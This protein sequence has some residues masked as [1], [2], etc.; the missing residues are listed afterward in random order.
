MITAYL[1]KADKGSLAFPYA[2]HDG[3]KNIFE[4][5][6]KDAIILLCSIL[7]DKIK[8]ST[9]LKDKNFVV[10]STSSNQAISDQKTLLETLPIVRQSKKH[11]VILG[12]GRLFQ[13]AL[14]R[15][16]IDRV[17]IVIPKNKSGGLLPSEEIQGIFDIIESTDF[18]SVYQYD[19]NSSHKATV[20]IRW[21]KT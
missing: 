12:G 16:L 9:L 5:I 14:R 15:K 4:S 13:I 3:T 18:I 19:T 7:Y 8:D 1:V 20:D 11:I 10:V 17:V 6:T 2:A 21:K